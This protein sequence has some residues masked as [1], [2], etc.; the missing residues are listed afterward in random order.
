MQTNSSG[1]AV[2]RAFRLPR[3]LA[4]EVTRRCPLKCRHCRAAAADVPYGDELSTDECFRVIDSL[5]GGTAMVIWTGGEPM[6]RPDLPRLVRR[7]TMRGLRSVMAPCGA[8]VTEE[9][10]RE[11]GDAGVMACSFSLDGPDAATHD[12]FRGVPGAFDMILRAMDAARKAGMPF[13][14]N[15]TVS[16]LNFDRL[17]EIYSLAMEKGATRL[18]VFS[19]V[20]VGRGKEIDRYVLPDDKVREL[21]AWSKAH[22]CKLTCCPMAGTCLGGM[23]FA[24]LSHV[25]TLQTCGFVED[26][27]GNVRDFDFNFKALCAAA[28][29]PIA[30][31]GTCRDRKA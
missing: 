29:N 30:L 3:V 15:A 23:G 9:R 13:Q 31:H 28:V 21:I 5:A 12:E 16:T 1:A 17:D 24:F 27:C 2:P 8:F 11:L 14:V 6:T 18:D 19:L 25:G 22:T 4:W 10:L 20:P 7:A 26:P